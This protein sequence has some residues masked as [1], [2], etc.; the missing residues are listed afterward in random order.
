MRQR[1][2]ADREVH[3]AVRQRQRS[4]VAGLEP[5]PGN[6]CSGVFQHLRRGIDTDHPV[7][8]R[9]QV[10]GVPAGAACRVERIAGRVARDHLPHDRLLGEHHRV[11]RRVVDRRPLGVAARDRL[12]A[13]D[14]GARP[15]RIVEAAC[16]LNDAPHARLDARRVHRPR[17]H[18]AEPLEA[19]DEIAERGVICHG[20]RLLRTHQHSNSGVQPSWGG[21]IALVQD[22]GVPASSASRARTRGPTTP[23][24]TPIG[25]MNRKTPPMT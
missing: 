2:R 18:D 10:L 1:E 22:P 4:E 16:H 19:E 9:R 14:L 20:Q 8:Q 23:I 24:S 21:G 15:R 5:R 12:L 6:L 25:A 11:A 13:H 3:R 17:A 7:T